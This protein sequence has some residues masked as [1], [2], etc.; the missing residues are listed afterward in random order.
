MEMPDS[1]NLESKSTENARAVEIIPATAKTIH[2]ALTTHRWARSEL[3][4]EN[5]VFVLLKDDIF[6]LKYLHVFRQIALAKT[7]HFSDILKTR[8]ACF[9]YRS[10]LADSLHVSDYYIV[11]VRGICIQGIIQGRWSFPFMYPFGV[12]SRDTFRKSKVGP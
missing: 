10:T 8:V 2:R 6:T 5:M 3:R 9:V 12:V 11:P 7:C 1:V 4:G